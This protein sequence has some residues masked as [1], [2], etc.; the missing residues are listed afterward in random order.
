[1]NE[2]AQKAGWDKASKL[3]NRPM[4]QGA[5]GVVVKRNIAI[6]VEVWLFGALFNRI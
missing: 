6:M 1:M 5:I 2:E 3:A 4:S